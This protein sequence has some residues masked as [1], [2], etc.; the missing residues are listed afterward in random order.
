MTVSL[1]TITGYIGDSKALTDPAI[2]KYRIC[3]QGYHCCKHHI[4]RGEGEELRRGSV[5]KEGPC[6]LVVL[7]VPL[8]DPF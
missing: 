1:V 7:A 2:C 6:K 8:L 5:S 4:C 3:F